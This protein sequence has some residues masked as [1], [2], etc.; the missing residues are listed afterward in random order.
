MRRSRWLATLLLLAAV[1]STGCSSG[2]GPRPLRVFA[3]ASLRDVF[4]TI[5]T[6]FTDSTGIPV[7]FNFAGSQQLV[8]QLDAGARADVVATADRTTM[9]K[10]GELLAGAPVVFAHNR[11][12]IVVA[13]GNPRG[14]RTLAD[15]ARPGL[16]VVLAAR[17]VPAGRYAAAA[18]DAAGVTVTPRSYEPDVRAVVAK[19]ALGEA[20]AGICYVTD[21]RSREGVSGVTIP[22]SVN[23]VADYPAALLRGA[24]DGA[25]GFL[26]LLSEAGGRDALERAGFTVP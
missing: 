11:L 21:V 22:D 12:S 3:A 5:G 7:E 26:R 19:V 1:A 6:A 25:G 23:Q 4:Q 10:L 14:V 17:G 8:A 9:D 15:L 16:L 18:L 2:A 13:A 20:D 24:R